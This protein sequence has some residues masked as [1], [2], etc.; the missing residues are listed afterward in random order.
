MNHL[1]VGLLLA[2]APL[3]ETW[4][5]DVLNRKKG[6]DP[7]AGLIVEQTPQHVRIKQVTRKAGKPTVVI[8]MLIPQDEV[9]RVDRLD[10]K[11]RAVL[12]GRLETLSRERKVLQAQIR[13]WKGGKLDLP[14][15]E[16]LELKPADWG[17]GKGKA[18]AYDSTYF[19]LV[20]NAREDIVL[21]TAI[22]L[23]QVFTAAARLFPPRGDTARP[24]TIL[25]TS[26]VLEYQR[27]VR[28]RG[29]NILNPAFF[30]PSRNQVV[31]GSDLERISQ[32][33]ARVR[34]QHRQL[35][36]EL[37]AR[38]KELLRI[39]NGQIPPE[40]LGPIDAAGKRI[41]A[42]EEK[43]SGLVKAYHLRMVQCLCHEA[44]H[45][46]L[47]ASVFADRKTRVPAWLDEG[48]A[49]VFETALVEGGELQVGTPDRERLERVQAALK[50][51]DFLALKDVL[52]STAK[53]FQVAHVQD[54]QQ[55]DQYYLAAWAL[56]FFLTFDQ[57][58]LGSDKLDEFLA[59]LER[60]IDVGEAF[61]KL[62][63]VPLA[64]AE[65]KW[66]AYLQALRPDGTSSARR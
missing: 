53:Q 60:G 55:S 31:C 39:Y 52:R 15:S 37:E 54:K 43:N 30:D 24:T 62:V 14:P 51:K 18:L 65:T 40:V 49:Q 22:Q 25:L 38:R 48:L 28:E 33:L 23:E 47:S 29:H 11:E 6:R 27:L 50:K 20:S 46:Y 8:E 17:D 61:G 13:L 16:M 19:R 4:K 7:L 34:T 42:L 10:D 44:F 26:S 58:V 45:A 32:E 41:K 2:Q 1:L 56:A 3:A 66:Y 9:D 21:L 5:L 63:G 57:S 12:T 64:T 59:A 36:A 35:E